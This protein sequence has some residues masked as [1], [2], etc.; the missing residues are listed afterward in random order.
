MNDEIRTG[1]LPASLGNDKGIR[2]LVPMKV[3]NATVFVEQVGEAVAIES[4][5]IR[6]VSPPSPED[7]FEKAGEILHECVR[8]L[9]ERIEALATKARPSEVSIE[10]SL[11]FE[12][13][14]KTSI[15]P[16]FASAEAGIQT[17]LKVTA[18][19]KQKEQAQPTTNTP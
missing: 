16:I 12:A 13:K 17:G 5:E 9:G 7:A 11:N 4:D 19:W 3:G 10:F 15:I 18:V 6:T 1:Q 14:G 2:H 8:V